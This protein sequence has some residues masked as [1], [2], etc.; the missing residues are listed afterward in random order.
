MKESTEIHPATT[1]HWCLI[2]KPVPFL[3][4]KILNQTKV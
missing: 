1:Y 4:R 3:L 2:L